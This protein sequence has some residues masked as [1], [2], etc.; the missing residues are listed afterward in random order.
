MRFGQ[1]VSL[2]PMPPSSN[3]KP[4]EPAALAV[5]PKAAAAILETLGDP[6]RLQLPCIP[7]KQ[8]RESAFHRRMP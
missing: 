7:E 8:V 1:S 5:Q 2:G 3:S 6:Q 4:P